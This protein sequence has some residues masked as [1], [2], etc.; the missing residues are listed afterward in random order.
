[1]RRCVRRAWSSSSRGLTLIELLVTLVILSILAAA[2]VPYAE[3]AVRRDKEMELRRALRQVRTAI[4]EFHDDWREGG[5]SKTGDGVSD[6]GFP[7]TLAVLVE[8]VEAGDAKGGTRKYLRRIP[9]DPFA[10][11]TVDPAEQWSLRGYQDE[12]DAR[13]WNRVD[14]YD[15]R[16]TSEGTAI[17]GTA[18]QNW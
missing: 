8:G 13:S 11:A 18:Y 4:D 9:R 2:A 7:K 6:D 16:T 1:V 10:E 17:D 3:L 12:T 14:V 5:I 15:I